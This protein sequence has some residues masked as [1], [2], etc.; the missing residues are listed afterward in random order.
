MHLFS[1]KEA[2]IGDHPDTIIALIPGVITISCAAFTTPDIG[3]SVPL[4]ITEAFPVA[5]LESVHP[6]IS[7]GTLALCATVISIYSFPGF[8]EPA[9][10]T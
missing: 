2:P 3:T 4:G 7:T 9:L 6:E 5:S 1:R 8:D 10:E